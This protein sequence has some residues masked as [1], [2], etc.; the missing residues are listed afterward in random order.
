MSG[1]NPYYPDDPGP[2]GDDGRY[3]PSRRRAAG[4]LGPRFVKMTTKTLSLLGG[5]KG[6]ERRVADA[7]IAACNG[8]RKPAPITASHAQI[9]KAADV[10]VRTVKRALAKME[11][12][13]A[14]SVEH[15]RDEGK[16]NRYWPIFAWGPPADGWAKNSSN[17]AGTAATFGLPPCP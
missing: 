17:K 2:S 6:A 5:L 16:R 11:A 14:L 15:C 4:K 3:P 7:F 12:A 1:W 8:R 10:S 13:G 9:A